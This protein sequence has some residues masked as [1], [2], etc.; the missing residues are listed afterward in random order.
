MTLVRV[1]AVKSIKL[2]TEKKNKRN[3]IDNIALRGVVYCALQHFT[4]TPY[5]RT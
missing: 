1:V 5:N 2:A 4:L 3:E